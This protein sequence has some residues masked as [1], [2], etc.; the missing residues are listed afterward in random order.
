MNGVVL[1]GLHAGMS[2]AQVTPGPLT[3]TPGQPTTTTTGGEFPT[4][5]LTTLIWVTLAAALV[6]IFMPERTAEQRGRIRLMALAGTTV[7]VLM[8]IGGL[9]YQI[10]QEGSG[11]FSYVFEEKHQ[12]IT[13]FSVHSNYHLGVDG[14]SLPLLLL[15][16]VLFVVAVLASWR[17]ERRVRLYFVLLLVLETGV[18]GFFCSLDYVLLFLFYEVELVPM[19]LL[20]A[21]WGGPRRMHAAWKFLIFMLT[22]SALLLAAILLLAF[23]G[24]AGSFDF[25]QLNTGLHLSAG[26]ATAGFWLT[27]ISFAIKLPVVPLHTWLPD[28]HVEASTPVSVILAGILLK[29]GGYGMLRVVLGAFPDA[30]KRYSLAIVALAVVSAIWGTLA[31]L[32][33][34]D[35]KR[36]V[37]YG[38]IGHMAIVLLAVGAQSS[39]ALNGAVLQMVAHGFITGLLFLL[40][41]TVYDRTRTRSISRLGGLAWQMPRLTAIWVFAGL[42][43]LGLP[44]L[45][46]FVAEFMVFTGAFPTHRFATVVVMASIAITTG[47]LLWMLQRVFFGPAKEAYE[48]LRD[49]STLELFYLVPMVVAVTIFG[50]VPGRIMPVINN[51]VATLVA[52]LSGSV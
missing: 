5:L 14:V 47:Y 13:A 8:A 39:I 10:N 50:V 27:F 28:A 16:T 3:P 1:S 11:G 44:F 49:A 29:L 45:A 21:I 51:G 38:S 33:Q 23:K 19:F 24:G 4:L 36:L 43:S 12:W 32:A 46:G 26:I 40:V 35:L 15:S 7:P 17:N 31:A 6:I 2:L 52:R 9:N 30:A 34:D 48:R 37:A 20:I 25:D 18:N 22:S 41:G 42:A